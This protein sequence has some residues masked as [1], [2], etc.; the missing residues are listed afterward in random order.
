MTSSSAS[1]SSAGVLPF[2]VIYLVAEQLALQSGYDLLRFAR[3][4]SALRHAAQRAGLAVLKAQTQELHNTTDPCIQSLE[5]PPIPLLQ[6]CLQKMPYVAPPYNAFIHNFSS[7][8]A[9]TERLALRNISLQSVEV[10]DFG[11][12]PPRAITLPL[13][14]R[15]PCAAQ[16]VSGA[17]VFDE[18]GNW[19]TVTPPHGG[20]GPRP[21]L[22]LQGLN[23]G[24]GLRLVM[25]ETPLECNAHMIDSKGALVR[26]FPLHGPSTEDENVFSLHTQSDVRLYVTYPVYNY[27]IRRWTLHLSPEFDPEKP[28]QT[29]GVLLHRVHAPNF[30]L[31]AGTPPDH[32]RRMD[33]Q[34]LFLPSTVWHAQHA[35]EGK[36]KAGIFA[37]QLKL[38]AQPSQVSLQSSSVADGAPSSSSRPWEL[39]LKWY[40]TAHAYE[41]PT[42]RTLHLA[43]F[44]VKALLED[45][46]Q[47]EIREPEPEAPA[48]EE[49]AESKAA[50][51][52]MADAGA[53]YA[54]LLAE[55]ID[56]SSARAEL[57][58]SGFDVA[59]VDAVAGITTAAATTLV[60]TPAKVLPPP[61]QRVAGAPLPVH[62][63]AIKGAGPVMDTADA[64]SYY[65]T[66]DRLTM[67]VISHGDCSSASVRRPRLDVHKRKSIDDEWSKISM[68]YK[69][70]VSTH[71]RILGTF[72]DW[73]ILSDRTTGAVQLV[74]LSNPRPHTSKKYSLADPKTTVT[75]GMNGDA[76]RSLVLVSGRVLLVGSRRVHGMLSMMEKEPVCFAGA[77]AVVRELAQDINPTVD[78]TAWLMPQVTNTYGH[79][80]TFNTPI[81][82]RPAILAVCAGDKALNSFFPLLHLWRRLV[83]TSMH[84]PP[85]KIDLDTAECLPVLGVEYFPRTLIDGN[86]IGHIFADGPSEWLVDFRAERAIPLIGSSE[87][88]PLYADAWSSRNPIFCAER[89]S[90]EGRVGKK[91]DHL[92]F[93]ASA[94]GLLPYWYRLHYVN[95]KTQAEESDEEDDYAEDDE[96]V[97]DWVI[98]HD[99][100]EDGTPGRCVPNY[101]FLKE[102]ATAVYTGGVQRML[103]FLKAAPAE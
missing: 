34:Y 101:V 48:E 94:D 24:N 23:I 32:A 84:H 99:H 65:I 86:M 88:N 39:E 60:A 56:K 55:G 43:F 80:I 40:E 67:F 62:Y 73:L 93:T 68:I 7:C 41:C 83:Q 16:Q 25:S 70:E 10:V 92:F 12:F 15:I 31:P 58:D 57:L 71:Q 47:V 42:H 46:M 29:E 96:C 89:Y 51:I 3:A 5:T 6:T 8:F 50:A 18:H 27:P 26:T 82:K 64:L 22:T 52:A 2:E 49:T 36:C 72:R 75:S 85:K 28:S 74:S 54:Q 66:E 9:E 103:S 33:M 91:L 79:S 77:A 53:L 63:F 78:W 97:Y 81:T 44:P 90:E 30:A 95:Q 20:L 4:S 13:R 102:S 100:D 69:I 76:S 37:P 17:K 98:G 19:I 87:K 21:L 38:A 1:S 11:Q 59:T 45:T 14:H 61:R 35:E